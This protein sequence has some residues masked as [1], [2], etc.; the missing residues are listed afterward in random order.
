VWTVFDGLVIGALSDDASPGQPAV[1]AFR[2][3]DLARVW[4]YKLNPGD[5]VKLIHPCAQHLVCVSADG[6][7]D[8][9][10]MAVRTTT[11]AAAWSKPVSADS[12]FDPGGYVV[13]NQFLYGDATF[14]SMLG[15]PQDH[16][17]VLD[18]ATG[19]R[20]RDLG[21]AYLMAAAGRYA[22]QVDAVG[23]TWQVRLLA[24]TTGK[25]SGWL[26]TTT[27]DLPTGLALSDHSFA[28]V[29][30]DRKL[31]VATAPSLS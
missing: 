26:S 30:K 11:G 9:T 5:D 1:G 15:G 29:T 10:M 14:D 18:T 4:T 31:Y 12:S 27:H 3:G 28:V 25:T 8:N 6:S 24:P 20:R 23:E 16:N 19:A 2:V 21:T 17:L 13:D 7:D 22:L